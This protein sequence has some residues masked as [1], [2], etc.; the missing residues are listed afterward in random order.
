MTGGKKA[1]NTGQADAAGSAS[2]DDRF[3]FFFWHC[4]LRSM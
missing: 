2:D 1:S 3:A 4:K